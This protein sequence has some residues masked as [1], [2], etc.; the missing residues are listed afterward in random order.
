MNRPRIEIAGLAAAFR[1]VGAVAA[2]G[3]LPALVLAFVIASSWRAGSAL[4]DFHGDLYRAGEAILHG[5]DPYR[6]AFLDRLAAVARAGGHPSQS[7]A[8]PIYPPPALVA[9]A[10]LALLSLH[11]AGL[12]FTLLQLA[13]AGAGLWLLGVRD[14]RCFGA[15]ALSWPVVHSVRLGQVNGVLVLAAG[16]AWRW[17]D[18]TWRPAVAVAAG[19]AMKI[20]LWPLGVWLLITRRWRVASAAVVAAAAA[21]LAASAVTGLDGLRAYPRMLGDLSAIEAGAGISLVSLGAALDV[22]RV[23]METLGWAIAT[24]LLVL[25]RGDDRTTFALAVSAALVVSPL[26]WPHYLELLFV[27]IALSSTRLSALWLVP[28]VAYL[29][30]T[31]PTHGRAWQIALY[32]SIE[33]VVATA[34]IASRGKSQTGLRRGWTKVW[35]GRAAAER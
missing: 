10:P 23:I 25:A 16:A 8:V 17:R 4:Y 20:L 12:V 18:A 22:P 1:T 13:A 14:W 34:V 26:V 35:V 29:A 5:H 3:V 9:L 24:A 11:A 32:L 31:E 33:L 15:A 6:A 21:V 7:F 2:F 30:P 19:V 27:P 28:L